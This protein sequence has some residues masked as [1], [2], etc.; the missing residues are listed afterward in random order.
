MHMG[1]SLI[2]GLAMNSSSNKGLC[3]LAGLV[4][5][6]IWTRY[7]WFGSLHEAIIPHYGESKEFSSS[8]TGALLDLAVNLLWGLGSV[9]I[10]LLSAGRWI[11]TDVLS[12]VSDFVKRRMMKQGEVA[13]ATG[14][15]SVKQTATAEPS[16]RAIDSAKLV[17]VLESHEVRL[18]KLEKPPKVPHRRA[19]Y[20]A[21]PK[22]K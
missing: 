9:I 11:A 18:T 8:A 6:V 19:T 20:Q 21:K 2:K 14:V 15:V 7:W 4:A 13:A 3:V 5:V 22:G 12:G 17:S 10:G 16:Q 1:L